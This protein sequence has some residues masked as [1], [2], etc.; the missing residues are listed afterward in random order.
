M[1]KRVI[2]AIG[3]FA[4]FIGALC[5]MTAVAET[6]AKEIRESVLRF[7]IIA[8]S[9]CKTD[10]DNKFMVRDGIAKLCENLFE[11]SKNKQ[12]SIEIAQ[13]NKKIIIEKAKEI[14]QK[15]GSNHSVEV[16]IRKRFFPTRHYEGVSLPAGVYDT[17]DVKIGA[18]EGKNFW[19]VMFP[20]IC[21]G[22]SSEEN[23]QKMSDVLSEESYEIVTGDTV[24]VK[25]KFKL[26]EIFETIKNIF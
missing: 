8:N 6:S 24:S 9:D 10:Q 12:Q 16:D 7:H 1:K 13:N 26:V 15:N 22:S 23:K 14:L 4:S 25:F 3:L 20:G 21:L 2:L 11:D 17:I 19:C 5:I 18:A